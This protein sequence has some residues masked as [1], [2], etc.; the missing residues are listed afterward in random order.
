MESKIFFKGVCPK[1]K[2]HQK[3]NIINVS[4]EN[5][6]QYAESFIRDA[7]REYDYE[8]FSI[9]SNCNN[10]KHYVSGNVAIIWNEYKNCNAMLSDFASE[11][12]EIKQDEN[13]FIEFDVPP[14]I[15]QQHL[16]SPPV[17]DMHF[18]YEQ[19][20][21]C[22]DIHA[23]DAV[24]ILCRKVI[25]IQSAKMWWKMF[26]TKPKSNL[27]A[28][29]CKILAHGEVFDKSLPIEEQ[30]D[31]SNENHRLLYDIERIRSL[32]NF[33]AHSELCVHSDDAEGALIY[34]QSFMEA[35]Y[36]WSNKLNA[37]GT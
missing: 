10:C 24:V 3:F 1:C 32:G 27:Y 26:G 17:A 11:N 20:N 23:W 14:L 4:C 18:L 5:E 9:T 22:Y 25:D 6:S 12:G 34:T 30:L 15:P 2:E 7:W 36:E 37:S 16:S 19:A 21:R 8:L 13:I 35:Y 28:R 29:V 33:S 31:F